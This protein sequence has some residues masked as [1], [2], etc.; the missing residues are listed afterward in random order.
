MVSM[1]VSDINLLKI[2]FERSYQIEDLKRIRSSKL[3]V[4]QQ[5]FFI[6]LNNHRVIKK[7]IVF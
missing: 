5:E 7:A 1:L 3:R 4:N 2:L 6:A